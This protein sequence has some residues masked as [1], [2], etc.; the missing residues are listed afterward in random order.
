[1]TSSERMLVPSWKAMMLVL[2]SARPLEKVLEQKLARGRDLSWGKKKVVHLENHWVGSLACPMEFDWD[3]DLDLDLER[4]LLLCLLSSSSSD[5]IF[6]LDLDLD[7]FLLE[8]SSVQVA[9]WFS[10]HVAMM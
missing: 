3:L 9:K 4:D 6:R 8:A 5:M 1:M 2:L 7:D 10:R